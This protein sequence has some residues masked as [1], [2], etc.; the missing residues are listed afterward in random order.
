[1]R[2]AWKHPR[3][4]TRILCLFS[5]LVFASGVTIWVRSYLVLD[6]INR[7]TWGA[8]KVDFYSVDSSRGELA[9]NRF[10]LIDDSRIEAGE[11]GWEHSRGNPTAFHSDSISP[12]DRF[13]MSLGGFH[14]RYGDYAADHGRNTFL[15][16]VLPLWLFFPFAVPPA[17]WLR[18]H[19]KRK[20]RG[21]PWRRPKGTSGISVIGWRWCWRS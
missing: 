12:N 5:L 8:G 19:R 1:M 21:F 16:L 17:I 9:V 20:G 7:R 11:F 15:S 18:N 13:N 3:W 10:T 2:W 6:N 14:L 4:I